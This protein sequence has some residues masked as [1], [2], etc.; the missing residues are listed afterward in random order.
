MIHQRLRKREGAEDNLVNDQDEITSVN[1]DMDSLFVPRRPQRHLV[2]RSGNNDPVPTTSYTSWVD[3]A[4]I[5][6]TSSILPEHTGQI[7]LFET[8]FGTL[9]ETL[10]ETLLKRFL[11]LSLKRSLKR[12]LK[13]F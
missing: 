5:S 7:S 12:C 3:P 9:F 10:F 8:L 4:T 1:D 2:A 6:T 11:K 13:S